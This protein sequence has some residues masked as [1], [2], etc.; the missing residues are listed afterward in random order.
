MRMKA[1][2]D[3]VKHA[4]SAKN[5]A[6]PTRTPNTSDCADNFLAANP[7]FN[8]DF[9]AGSAGDTKADVVLSQ[10]YGTTSE[11]GTLLESQ[12]KD[13]INVGAK[14]RAAEMED[15]RNDLA[16]AEERKRKIPKMDKSEE[17]D[18]SFHPFF[19]SKSTS[20]T[21]NGSSKSK[22]VEGKKTAKKGSRIHPKSTALPNPSIGASKSA[23]CAR[24]LR[25]QAQNGEFQPSEARTQR[26]RS[27]IRSESD[28]NATFEPTSKA[29]QCSVCKKW[30]QGKESY[31]TSQFIEHWKKGCKGHAPPPPAPPDTKARTLE[32]FALMPLSAAKRLKAVVSAKI[33]MP[34]PG[35]TAAY[36]EKV[37]DYLERSNANGGGAR[38]IGHYSEKLF[39]KDFQDLSEHQ[40]QLAYAAQQHG[41]TWQNDVTEGIMAS[42]ATGTTACLKNVEIDAKGAESPPPCESCLLLFTSRAYQNVLNKPQPDPKICAMCHTS[43]KTLMRDNNFSVERRYVEHVLNGSF[44]NDSVFNGIVQAK[45]L[46]KDREL[47]GLGKKPQVLRGLLS[48]YRTKP[49]ETQSSTAKDYGY[50]LDAALSLSVDDTKLHAAL[51]PLYNGP[52]GKWFIVGT[53]GEPI[54]VPDVDA[55]NDTLDRLEKTAEVATKICSFASG[56]YRFLFLVFPPLALAIMPISPKLKGAQL[57]E[58]QLTLMKGLIRRGFRITSSGGDGASVE[59]ECQRL[60]AAASKVIEHRIKHPDPDYPDIVVTVWELDGNVWTEIQ[61]AKHGRKTFQN[62]ASSGARGLVLGNVVVYFGQIYRLAMEPDSP[63]YPRD[64]QEKRNRMDDPAAARLFSA[65]TLAQA[66]KDPENNLGLVVYLLV[67]GD[68]IDAY[69]SQTLSHHERAK[70]AIRTHLFLQTWC[71]FLQKAGY[72]ESRHFISKEAFA[73]SEILANG[74]LG[75]IFIHRNHL[76]SKAVLIVPKL[77]AK[78]QASVRTRPDPASYKKQ[79]SGY[80]HTYFTSEDIDFAPLGQYPTDVELSMAYKIA[81][82]ENN[83]LWTLLGIHPDQIN[84]A[85]VFSLVP[86]PTPDPAFE[87]LYLNEDDLAAQAHGAEQTAAEEVQQIIDNLQSTVGLSRAEDEQLDACVMA[88]V[89]LSMDELARIEDLPDSDP[90]RFAEI[91]RDIAHAMATQPAAFISLLQGMVAA[92]MGSATEN[93]PSSQPLVDVSSSDLEPLVALRREH[94]TKEERM[95]VRTYRASGTYTTPKTRI[96]KEL[97]PR[98]RLA[99]AMGAIVKREH[100]QGSSTGLNRQVRW[101]NDSTA[102]ATPPAKTG[103]AANA[104]VTA[105]GRA[106][107]TIKR[108]RTIFGKLKCL[109][110]VVEAGIGNDSVL[111]NGSYGFASIGSEIVL[112][113]GKFSYT[114]A[115]IDTNFLQ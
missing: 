14:R 4:L 100:Q 67:F 32:Q 15:V 56:S 26:F 37:G 71:S 61:D 75:L 107:E 2:C 21:D 98:Q 28:K 73:I 96:T 104:E 99:Q 65:D 11:P 8:D 46:A 42:F 77:R 43:I 34:C 1:F 60:T 114:I 113:R 10:P 41:H 87:H 51:R 93:L 16:V 25:I 85:P 55:L 24:N 103:N 76:G 88:S 23:T 70:I 80:C 7:D 101:K 3:I 22:A 29:V 38:A 109:S 50:P 83:C 81:A 48:A 54:E 115:V 20:L 12:S 69:Q 45:V 17:P 53:T 91:Q 102:L 13:S 64:V 33:S 86:Q 92:S 89:A 68:F 105:A 95:G 84:S 108:R 30:V 6:Q 106:K 5:I 19:T 59:C 52:L 36:S 79:A 40:Q 18:R 90:E 74:L 82:E 78:M 27:T 63:M 110:T 49:T 111:E 35:L 72:P 31:N 97:T 94:Q 112:A 66:A 62:N 44:K 9:P 39:K 47:K 57:A 58:W